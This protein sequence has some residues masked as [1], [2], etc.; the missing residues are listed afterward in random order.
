MLQ[1][2]QFRGSITEQCRFNL[3]EM[4]P[5]MEGIIL[6]NQYMITIMPEHIIPDI[7]EEEE[8]GLML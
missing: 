8:S 3:S 2:L 1:F 4:K 5:Y 7:P 6:L